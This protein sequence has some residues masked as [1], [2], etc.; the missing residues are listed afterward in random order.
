MFSTHLTVPLEHGFDCAAI[1]IALLG[2][3]LD[4]FIGLGQLTLDALL[5]FIF[6]SGLRP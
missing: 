1:F 2:F 6:L 3:F 5:V 4:Q